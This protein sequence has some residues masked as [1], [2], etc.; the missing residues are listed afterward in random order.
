MGPLKK[1][2]TVPK[3]E[4]ITE[5]QLFR[6]LTASVC[7]ILLCL[8]C[9]VSTTWAWFTVEVNSGANTIQIA[10][11]TPTVTVEGK[12][13]NP[14]NLA[15]GVHK[16]T[17]SLTRDPEDGGRKYGYVIICVTPNGSQSGKYYYAEVQINGNKSEYSIQLNSDASLTYSAAW[18][19][20]ENST[21]NPITD[22]APKT[23]NLLQGTSKPETT[24]AP[25]ETTTPVETTVPE[26]TETTSAAEPS[27]D[28]SDPTAETTETTEPA[29][30]TAPTETSLPEA[31]ADDNNE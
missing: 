3:N 11:L 18:I 8:T 16:L 27:G 12:G 15:Q 17:L 25:S 20:A 6:V 1:L 19:V 29:G 2:F 21:M 31:S 28:A 5:K 4:K 30:T 23:S 14:A 26:P 7:S 13:N 10:T 9:L 24:T 22:L